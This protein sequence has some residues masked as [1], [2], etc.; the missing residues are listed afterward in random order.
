MA[1]NKEVRAKADFVARWF[2]TKSSTLS[3]EDNKKTGRKIAPRFR[4][5]HDRIPNNEENC[6]WGSEE[7]VRQIMEFN[8]Y[9]SL[10]NDKNPNLEDNLKEFVEAA[11]ALKNQKQHTLAPPP[12]PQVSSIDEMLEERANQV[13]AQIENTANV[14]FPDSLGHETEKANFITFMNSTAGEKIVGYAC[15]L[16]DGL[17]LNYDEL[18]LDLSGLY[19][20]LKII[21]DNPQLKEGDPRFQ[22]IQA[23]IKDYRG[24]QEGNI[25]FTAENVKRELVAENELEHQ[26]LLA[27]VAIKYFGHKDTVRYAEFEKFADDFESALGGVTTLNKETIAGILADAQGLV[28]GAL[29]DVDLEKKTATNKVGLGMSG[30][31]KMSSDSFLK[32]RSED[33][34]AMLLKSLNKKFLD[35]IEEAITEKDLPILNTR[36]SQAGYE[37]TITYSNFERIQNTSK[38]DEV[39]AR[40]LLL[41]QCFGIN[42]AGKEAMEVLTTRCDKETT[43][44]FQQYRAELAGISKKPSTAPPED[45]MG[46]PVKRRQKSITSSTS[47]SSLNRD[48]LIIEPDSPD[49]RELKTLL[50]ETKGETKLQRKGALRGNRRKKSTTEPSAPTTDSTLDESLEARQTYRSVLGELTK[51]GTKTEN[52]SAGKTAAEKKTGEPP[53]RLEVSLDAVKK[54]LAALKATKP[55]EGKAPDD[56]GVD[57]E[58]ADILAKRRARTEGNDGISP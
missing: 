34:K 55:N 26:A 51:A 15:L 38:E 42:I 8:Q 5:I 14:L 41:E 19:D 25:S 32:L 53:L 43:R 10:V 48:A 33:R 57:S 2:N 18:F 24:A 29:S 36:L 56:S 39:S 58:L 4:K 6:A 9:L 54:R 31:S 13:R 45:L 27:P 12:A 35:K 20:S 49:A 44:R 40:G 17:G 1:T 7:V 3:S 47:S 37:G 46:A 30:M 21:C 50:E 23:T 16:V 28:K 22:I 11:K 52:L